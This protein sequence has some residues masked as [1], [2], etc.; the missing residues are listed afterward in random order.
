M[1]AE[2]IIESGYLYK[3]STKIK[4]WKKRWFVLRGTKLAYY[5]NEKEYKLMSVIDLSTIHR[6]GKVNVS[7]PNVFG[8]VTLPRT[9]YVQGTNEEDVDNW[10]KSINELI[11][12]NSNDVNHK[13]RKLSLS[14]S[15]IDK[16]H[17]K[18]Y[19]GDMFN[20]KPVSKSHDSLENFTKGSNGSIAGKTKILENKF[21]A[22]NNTINMTPH[23]NNTGNDNSV[24]KEN[25]TIE[26]NNK[27]NDSL[28][29]NNN[30]DNAINND[31]ISNLENKNTTNKESSEKKKE[32]K[33]MPILT[34]VNDLEVNDSSKVKFIQSASAVEY[35]SAN[36]SL[37]CSSKSGKNS[38]YYNEIKSAR[39][40]DEN[41]SVI[42]ENEESSSEE[43]LF[44]VNPL[45]SVNVMNDN[46]I[47]RQ[48]YLLRQ[49]MK[50]KTWKKRWFVL[51]NGK[52]TCYKNEKEYVVIFIIP[53]SET[54]DIIETEKPVSKSH[55]YCFKVITEGKTMLL[56][57]ETEEDC[58]NW[59]SDLQRCHKIIQEIKDNNGLVE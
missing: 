16:E 14:E 52:L 10:I 15:N 21:D 38:S 48:G 50:Y 57:S 18:E 7:R 2:K 46:V 58:N 9:Y 1:N 54:L 24:A 31:N 12:A 36:S 30:L 56:C 47:V 43:N 55:K 23:T 35:R 41:H 37:P 26:N 27:Q 13:V 5:K 29:T 44:I 11:K 25:N 59:I 40:Y 42:H 51:R 4:S 8:I 6:V 53:L 34:S 22:V 28:N 3:R 33:P 32:S 45:T 19:S 39:P 17:R 20:G 49:S